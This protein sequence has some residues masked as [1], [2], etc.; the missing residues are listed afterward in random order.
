MGVSRL[1]VCAHVAVPW[2]WVSS[3]SVTDA[4]SVNCSILKQGNDTFLSLILTALDGHRADTSF[5]VFLNAAVGW[6]YL[7]EDLVGKDKLRA[8]RWEYF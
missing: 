6:E 4:T 2:W 1:K 3:V 8:L 7:R 5:C